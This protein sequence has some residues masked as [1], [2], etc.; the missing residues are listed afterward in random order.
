MSG[1]E[2]WVLWGALGVSGRGLPA[3]QASVLRPLVC[4]P[5]GRL[6]ISLGLGWVPGQRL[7]PQGGG[8]PALHVGFRRRG[9]SLGSWCVFQLVTLRRREM[10]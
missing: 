10:A 7:C 8:D 1:G 5:C 4:G 9:G 2:G 6:E 3:L